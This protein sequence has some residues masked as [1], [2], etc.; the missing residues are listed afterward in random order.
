MTATG[1]QSLAE[2]IR[3]RFPVFEH[4][5]YLNTCSQGAMSDAVAAAYDSYL[6]T[7][8]SDG[9]A[10]GV[11]LE[12]AERLRRDYAQLLHTE[13]DAVAITASAS[14]AVSAVASAFEFGDRD[15]VVTTDL[16]FPTVGQIWHAHE[17]RGARVVHVPTGPDGTLSMDRLAAVLDERTALVSVTHVCY[18]NGS[19]ADIA[20]IIRLA[21]DH[22]ALVLVDSYQAVGAVPIDVGALGVDFLVGGSR[23][24]LLGSPGAD[25]LYV[26]PATTGHLVPVSTGWF[27]DEDVAAM[28]VD[29][30]RPAGTARRFE[31]GT[32]A[33]PS[34]YAATAG[35]ELV[36]EIGVPRIAAHVRACTDRLMAGVA[37]L[38]GVVA[39][40]RD[41]ARRGPLVAIASTDD[42]Q[43]VV[44]LAEA[45]IATS[46]RGGNVRV[47]PHCYNTDED[48]DRLLVELCTHRDLLRRP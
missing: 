32:P 17:R 15:T 33:I 23:K 41:P 28:R 11:W 35:V 37:E 18:R 22:G 8:A 45:R 43:L 24:Y 14:A 46:S 26:N 21:H 6:G 42:E 7:M 20:A 36:L 5:T 40:P 19:L 12:R 10:W 13:P 30:Y 9:A 3:H 39:T 29:A 16:E 27:A 47:A 4:R 38:G 44:R 1:E 2:G 25:F 34:V 48:V 31:A